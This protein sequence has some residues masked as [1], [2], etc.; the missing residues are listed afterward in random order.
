MFNTRYECWYWVST[1]R[2]QTLVAYQVL[3]VLSETTNRTQY[4][5]FESKKKLT[6]IKHRLH[7]KQKQ[8]VIKYF[9]FWMR[10][11]ISWYLRRNEIV[12]TLRRNKI[13]KALVHCP[14]LPPYIKLKRLS[15]KYHLRVLGQTSTTIDTVHPDKLSHEIF[16]NY[17]NIITINTSEC[18]WTGAK[19]CFCMYNRTESIMRHIN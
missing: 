14:V 2:S 11:N 6:V 7:F 4:K 10:S 16:I 19:W 1:I 18:H 3:K 17:C 5:Y 15:I 13:Q 12:S 9:L 8:G